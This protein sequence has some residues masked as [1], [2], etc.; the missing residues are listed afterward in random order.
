MRWDHGESVPIS[1]WYILRA[2]VFDTK[3]QR[4]S[5]EVTREEPFHLK[6]T[7]FVLTTKFL[8]HCFQTH[9]NFIGSFCPDKFVVC[10]CQNITKLDTWD[11]VLKLISFND[12]SSLSLYT[13][14]RL[15]FNM[16]SIW[17]SLNHD[18]QAHGHLSWN[19]V[20]CLGGIAHPKIVNLSVLYTLQTTPQF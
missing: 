1:I 4:K 7:Q 6:W 11:L 16:S 8:M 12:L 2:K 10:R 19:R 3:R 20:N 9:F 5:E 15:T 13:L 14:C 17:I 18:I